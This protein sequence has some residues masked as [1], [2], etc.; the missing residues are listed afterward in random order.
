M[1]NGVAA[2]E[3]TGVAIST[4]ALAGAAYRRDARRRRVGIKNERRDGGQSG[5]TY[6]HRRMATWHHQQHRRRRGIAAR[7]QRTRGVAVSACW[8]R[9]VSWQRKATLTRALSAHG[10]Q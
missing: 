9:R 6:R 8:Q 3:R 2:E 4:A 10:A 5:K 7:R 1:A